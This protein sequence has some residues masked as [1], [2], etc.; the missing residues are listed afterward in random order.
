MDRGSS[1]RSPR[2]DEQMSRETSGHVQGTAGSRA[3]EWHMPEPAGEDQPE[4]RAV[5]GYAAGEGRAGAPAGMSPTD[6]EQRS[7]L[8]KYLSLAALPGDREALR[9]NAEENNAPSD[10]LA[11]LDRLPSGAEFRNVAEVWAALGHSNETKR[12]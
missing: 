10:V 5:P 11:E 9:R 2:L 3:E 8:A 6:V 7:R 12:S 4:A 1:R